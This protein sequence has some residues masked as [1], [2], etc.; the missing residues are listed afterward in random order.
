VGNEEK[1]TNQGGSGKKT[2]G[3]EGLTELK[4]SHRL[5]GKHAS[6]KQ[7]VRLVLTTRVADMTKGLYGILLI[8][9]ETDLNLTKGKKDRKT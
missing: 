9:L 8:H 2:S 6:E 3:G 7:P 4:Q 1:G 5:Q